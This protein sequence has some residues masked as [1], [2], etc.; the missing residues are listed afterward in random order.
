MLFV[1]NVI[2][3]SE[4][5]GMFSAVLRGKWDDLTRVWGSG[6]RDVMSP[7]LFWDVS[8]GICEYKLPMCLVGR[9]NRKSDWVAFVCQ[10]LK[11]K[12]SQKQLT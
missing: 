3:R 6:W 12:L 10:V 2:G 1:G 4:R 8:L 9:D 7:Y 5:P 11:A